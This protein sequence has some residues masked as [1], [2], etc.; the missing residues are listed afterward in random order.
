MML[1]VPYLIRFPANPKGHAVTNEQTE[2]TQQ[3]VEYTSLG[4]GPWYVLMGK[5][6]NDAW[7]ISVL[8]DDQPVA[9]FDT[10]RDGKPAASLMRSNGRPRAALVGGESTELILYG[11]DGQIQQ[12]L[13]IEGIEQALSE[14]GDKA[15]D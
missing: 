3:E 5:R 1:P 10:I 7:T 13:S 15:S 6:P 14:S 4:V 11:E 12:V 2:E 9:G 8:K